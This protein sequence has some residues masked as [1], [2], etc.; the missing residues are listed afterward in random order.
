MALE[1]FGGLAHA[2]PLF[3]AHDRFLA[4]LASDIVREELAS[5]PYAEREDSAI[6]RSL[7]TNAARLDEAAGKVIEELLQHCR[8]Y[9]L[10][11]CLL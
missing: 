11:F 2:A 10:R 6:Y 4:A 7:Y 8:D 5:L 9:L 1:Y 3:E